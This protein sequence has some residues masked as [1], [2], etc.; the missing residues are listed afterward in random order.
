MERPVRPR[1]RLKRSGQQRWRKAGLPAVDEA[2]DLPL[3]GLSCKPPWNFHDDAIFRCQRLAVFVGLSL[4]TMATAAQ[5]VGD[6][7]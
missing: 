2:F 5:A 6:S 3:N 7:G 4:M 1:I